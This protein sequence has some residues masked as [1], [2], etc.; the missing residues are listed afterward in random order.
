MAEQLLLSEGSLESKE[1]PCSLDRLLYVTSLCLFL[2][3]YEEK[4]FVGDTSQPE[5]DGKDV[6]RVTVA[7]TLP[8]REPFLSMLELTKGSLLLFLYF[9]ESF[10]VDLVPQLLNGEV[11]LDPAAS[12]AESSFLLVGGEYLG[13][14][15]QKTELTVHLD[16]VLCWDWLEAEIA[17]QDG[18]ATEVE[19]AV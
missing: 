3:R 19:G 10:E 6:D 2:V 5:L 7:V 15:E 4:V 18:V 8:F 13:R 12:L 16:V 1:F 14:L 11:W 17:R 9:A